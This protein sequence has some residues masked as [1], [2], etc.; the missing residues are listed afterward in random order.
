MTPPPTPSFRLVRWWTALWL[1]AGVFVLT[2]AIWVHG[3]DGIPSGLGDGRLNQLILE[4]GFQSFRGHYDWSS[5]GQFHPTPHTLGWSDTHLG[6]LPIY[7]TLRGLSF[8]PE[9]AWQAWFVICAALNLVLGFR[10]FQQLGISTTY[11]GPL[12]FAAFAG[13]PTVWLAGTHPQLL[14][15]FPGLWALSHLVS[16]AQNRRK[17]HLAIF[18]G[19]ISAQFATG[20]YLAFFTGLVAL[21]GIGAFF[22]SRAPFHSPPPLSGGP[23]PKR[24]PYFFASIGGL[25]G[26][27]NLWI[28]THAVKTGATRP[29]SELFNLCPTWGDWFSP[30]AALAFYSSSTGASGALDRGELLLFTGFLPWILTVAATFLGWWFRPDPRAR[31]AFILGATGLSLMV[32]TVRWPNDFSIWLSLAQVIEPLRGFRAIGRVVV[33]SHALM[34]GA[35]GLL[36]VF[37]LSRLCHRPI[38]T[39]L[40]HTLVGVVALEGLSTHQPAYLASHA[41]ARREAV[42]AAWQQAGDREILAFA[43]GFTNQADV[44]LNLDAWAAAL[45]RQRV[46]L[47]GYG[48]NAPPGH[49]G[50]VWTPTPANARELA[51]RLKIFESDISVVTQFPPEV[52]AE[53]GFEYQPERALQNLDGFDLSPSAWSLFAPPERFDFEEGVFYQFTPH[54]EV[55][56]R[57]P[58]HATQLSFLVGGRPGS[59]SNGGDSDGFSLAWSVTVGDGLAS[60][61]NAEVINPRDIPAHRGFLSRS[62]K[63]PRGESRTLVLSFGPGPSGLNNWD[64]PLLGRLRVE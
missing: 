44:W 60:A 47:N 38:L 6:T 42:V 55:T 27:I 50:F 5:P 20:P 18:A 43:P 24:I 25:L 19:G 29:M 45:S 17:R 26:L 33:F 15:L 7:I 36:L 10:L 22:L 1:V 14:P 35:S 2:Q 49:L 40:I 58:D 56:F 54:A 13:A 53:L 16:F 9:R 3:G 62:I 34:V 41:I 61:A 51:Q 46:T 64:W 11:A 63:L 48:G 12:T 8:G 23:P 52:A 4:H 28:Y 32:F 57:L 59:Y 21:F 39:G 37:C 31:W 30:S